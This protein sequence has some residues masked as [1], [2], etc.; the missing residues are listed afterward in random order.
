MNQF[1]KP[2]LGS[3]IDPQHPLSQGCVMALLMLEGAGNRTYDLTHNG[4]DGVLT[5]GPLW[6]PGRNGAE[7]EFDGSND[8]VDCGSSA[9]LH[10]M[11]DMTC[12]LSVKWAEFPVST[13][14]MLIGT[15]Y[16]K[17]YVLQ[18]YKVNN[19]FLF[20]H[21]GSAVLIWYVSSATIDTWYHFVVVRDTAT[22]KIYLYKDGILAVTS[23]VYAVD[24]VLGT[25]NLRIG[26]TG[27][28]A[29]QYW[30]GSIDDVRIWDRA[31]SP[32]EVQDLFINP[33]GFIYQPQKYWLMPQGVTIPPHLFRRVA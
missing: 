29:Q 15:S 12:K 14:R 6:K 28:E 13:H 17:E 7:I 30:K 31:L 26:R 22:K 24:P 2:P 19:R 11:G 8:Y 21:G 27:G 33:Y 20:W 9:S 16:A 23:P 3:Q 32:D 5:N 1:N 18:N 25:K 4:N 10:L